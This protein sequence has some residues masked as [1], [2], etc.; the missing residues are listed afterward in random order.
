MA[1]KK[2][3]AKD[4]ALLGTPVASPRVVPPLVS[5]PKAN[6][7]SSVRASNTS[8]PPQEP[9]IGAEEYVAAKAKNS[10]ALKRYLLQH[11]G[12]GTKT[13]TEWKKIVEGLRVRK[14]S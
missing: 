3:A 5:R 13:S 7:A 6:V 2:R 9:K 12:G 10:P 1:R 14:I 11:Y 8:V 4:V